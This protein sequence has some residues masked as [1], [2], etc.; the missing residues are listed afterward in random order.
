MS[1]SLNNATDRDRDRESGHESG[2]ETPEMSRRSNGIRLSVYIS[3]PVPARLIRN[4][5]ATNERTRENEESTAGETHHLIQMLPQFV[6]F[7]NVSGSFGF[8]EFLNRAFQ[9]HQPTGPP[10]ASKRALETLPQVDVIKDLL[11]QQQECFICQE[12]FEIGEKINV[13]PCS[14]LYHVN[15]VMTWLKE[16]NTCPVCRYELETDD[17]D[18]ERERK[19][20]MLSR[21]EKEKEKEMKADKTDESKNVKTEESQEKVTQVT[22]NLSNQNSFSPFFSSLSTSIST[23]LTST[24]SST[25]S[26]TTSSPIITSSPS[27]FPTSTSTSTSTSS[28]MSSSACFFDDNNDKA[29]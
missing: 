25:S 27:T 19:R 14:H 28:S 12:N 13:L 11:Q 21:R 2:N 10:P 16:H 3:V 26:T 4:G 20:R 7:N 29:S 18:Y 22:D 8:H 15:C 17:E 24:T 1:D 9:Q 6:I 23:P 5:N